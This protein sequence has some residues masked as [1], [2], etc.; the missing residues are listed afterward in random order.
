MRDMVKF[1]MLSYINRGIKNKL[2]RF[3]RIYGFSIHEKI[4]KFFY[5]DFP[6]MHLFHVDKKNLELLKK[7]IPSLKKIKF[8][9]YNNQKDFKNSKIL[10]KK[11]WIFNKR[12]QFVYDQFDQTQEWF[13]IEDNQEIKNFI[14][15]LF[16]LFKKYL[17]SHFS[18]VNLRV[19]NNL[20]NGQPVVGRNEKIRGTYR[21]HTDGFPPGHVIVMIYLIPLDN[22][23]GYFIIEHEAIKDKESGLGIIFRNSDVLHRAVSGTKNNRYVLELT[24]QRTLFKVDQLKY[25]YPS[26]PDTMYLL[27]PLQA[28]F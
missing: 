7:I 19:W 12:D 18:V 17:K 14:K 11:S 2:A 20:P 28:Y 26:T 13:D 5:G 24:L 16:P 15:S 8:S 25:S 4:V 22:E 3:M 10:K 21:D 1:I 6:K 27:G 23:H 9:N